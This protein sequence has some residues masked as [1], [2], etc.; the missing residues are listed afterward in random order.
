MQRFDNPKKM[1]I[2]FRQ[3]ND[4]VVPT[5][6][7]KFVKID[8]IPASGSMSS[9]DEFVIAQALNDLNERIEALQEQVA[10]QPIDSGTIKPIVLSEL[11]QEGMTAEEL[12]NIGLTKDEIRAAV[13]G[14]RTGVVNDDIYF[15]IVC[16]S[17]GMY[18]DKEQLCFIF[19]NIR[20]SGTA[21]DS[22]VYFEVWYDGD[23]PRV[24]YSEI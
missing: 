5:D 23:T 16:A 19:E 7:I 9:D 4:V 18:N 20:R 24:V 21:I 8:G 10:Q 13:A 14:L 22:M 12:D 1:I 2:E 17:K 15:Q 6:N 11:P 3:G